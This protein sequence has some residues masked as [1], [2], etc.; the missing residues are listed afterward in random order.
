MRSTTELREEIFSAARSEFAQYGLAGARIDRIARSAQASKERLYAHF[1]DKE[2]LFREVFAAD[3]AEFFRS[4][5]LRPEA[6]PEFVGEVYDLGLR[7]PE[8]LRM[9]MWAQLEGFMLDEPQS[10]GHPIPA[11]AV[12][13]IEAAQAGGYV[14]SSWDSTDLL[15][16]LFS[17][18]LAWAQSPHPDAVTDDPAV[19][20]RRRAAAVEAAARIVAVAS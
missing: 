7:K 17:I 19:I 12:A 9:I 5:T 6:V 8:H 2:T 20:S 18:G 4:V 11:H 15:A 14:D 3:G 1:G 16:L 10:D 13:A